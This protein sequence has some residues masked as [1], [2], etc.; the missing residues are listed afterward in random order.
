MTF[1]K[2]TV[3]DLIEALS[4]LPEDAEIGAVEDQTFML[5]FNSLV[6][7]NKPNVYVINTERNRGWYDDIRTE[8]NFSKIVKKF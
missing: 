7:T 3:K 5:Q 4:L 1:T 2:V 8:A 6:E